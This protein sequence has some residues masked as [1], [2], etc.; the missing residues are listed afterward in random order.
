MKLYFVKFLEEKSKNLQY[1]CDHS[2]Q[3][4]GRLPTP[5]IWIFFH[6][7]HITNYWCIVKKQEG[8]NAHWWSLTVEYCSIL[9]EKMK[10]VASSLD[11]QQETG[12]DK[13]RGVGVSEIATLL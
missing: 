10:T 9:R 2:H 12:S 1:L 8:G 6:R 11:E 13:A 7:M 4:T 3:S 5:Q